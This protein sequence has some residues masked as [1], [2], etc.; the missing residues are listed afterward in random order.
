MQKTLE[1]WRKTVARVP[2]PV[3]IAA[4]AI[5]LLLDIAI[6]I[7]ALN[8]PQTLDINSPQIFSQVPTGMPLK[9]VTASQVIDYLQGH[10]VAIT[11]VRPYKLPSLKPGEE[12]AFN[13]QGQLVIV[14]SYTDVNTQLR[15]SS[16]FASGTNALPA[17]G[18]GAV[19][20]A[21]PSPKPLGSLAGRWN[22]DSVGNVILLTDKAMALAGRSMLVS[23][24]YTLVVAPLYPAYPTATNPGPNGG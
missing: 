18:R 8:S 5:F 3:I 23:H 2:T 10:H 1:S 4:A 19:T 17:M 11:D 6:V 24:V 7:R 22:M 16:Q 20:I 9:A 13:L 14:L 15:D 12:L 21:P